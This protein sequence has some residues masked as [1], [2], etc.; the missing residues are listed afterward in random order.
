MTSTTHAK[1]LAG[2]LFNDDDVYVYHAGTLE[3]VA[4]YGASSHMARCV[5]YSLGTG[6]AAAKG[7]QAKR[8]GLWRKI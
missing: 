3:L 2:H 7:M 4:V 1:P 8:L 6:M 5:L